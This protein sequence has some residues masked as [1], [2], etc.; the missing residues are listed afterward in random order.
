MDCSHLLRRQCWLFSLLKEVAGPSDAMLRAVRPA[1]PDVASGIPE[2]LRLRV[3]G[4]PAA[5][6]GSSGLS[7]DTWI[8]KRIKNHEAKIH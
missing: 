3:E 1:T 7:L 8:L 5:R 4:R 6:S 2:V